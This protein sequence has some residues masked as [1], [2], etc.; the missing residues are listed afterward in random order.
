MFAQI[1]IFYS[2]LSAKSIVYILG[3]HPSESLHL[4]LKKRE[5]L[6]CLKENAAAWKHVTIALVGSSI[7]L[8]IITGRCYSLQVY[9]LV[10]S[11]TSSMASQSVLMITMI[12]SV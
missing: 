3:L 9:Q 11:N 10:R 1:P 2:S 4:D 5:V 6:H 8:L 12:K 7:S